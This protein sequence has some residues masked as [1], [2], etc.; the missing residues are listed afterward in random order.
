VAADHVARQC[1][2][3]GEIAALRVERHHRLEVGG[4]EA[5]RREARGLVEARRRVDARLGAGTHVELREGLTGIEPPG[6]AGQLALGEPGAVRLLRARVLDALV[7]ANHSLFAEVELSVLLER[8]ARELTREQPADLVTVPHIDGGDVLTRPRHER[9]VALRGWRA[10]RMRGLLV[11]AHTA[12]AA[13]G[14]EQAARAG[15]LAER[16]H[17]DRSVIPSAAQAVAGHADLPAPFAGARIERE[18]L[19]ARAE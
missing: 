16:R 2:R 18:E 10:E 5:I 3:P 4:H 8:V 19:A 15:G 1:R 11:L 17:R 7:E 13:H 14:D 9:V 6:L 12:V